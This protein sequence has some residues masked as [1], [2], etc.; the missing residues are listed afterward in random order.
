M[1]LV[2]L[3]KAM[4]LLWL[5]RSDGCLLSYSRGYAVFTAVARFRESQ[6]AVKI[7]VPGFL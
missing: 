1:V 5:L 4:Q 3:E 2:G 7:D 6:L